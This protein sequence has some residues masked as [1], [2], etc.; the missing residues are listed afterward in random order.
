MRDVGCGAAGVRPRIGR[1]GP[2]DNPCWPAVSASA[3]D[4]VL[5]A[6]RSLPA[7]N[8]REPLKGPPQQRIAGSE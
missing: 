7:T 2:S 5:L 6:Q 4:H 1:W 3:A 8:V